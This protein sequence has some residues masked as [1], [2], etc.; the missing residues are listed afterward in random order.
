MRGGAMIGLDVMALD[1]SDVMSVAHPIGR[2]IFTAFGAGSVA[3]KLEQTERQQGWLPP[4]AP[5]ATGKPSAPDGKTGAHPS[6]PSAPGSAAGPTAGGSAASGSAPAAPGS[7]AGPT[8]T[9]GGSA[10]SGLPKPEAWYATKI[11]GPV[12]VWHAGVVA[13]LVA[14]GVFLRKARA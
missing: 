9:A 10:A 1:F 4:Q 7:A 13:V 11:V 3:D 12:R 8:P 14:A 5:G 2:G 6:A